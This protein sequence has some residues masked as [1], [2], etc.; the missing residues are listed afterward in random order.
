MRDGGR[1]R[2]WSGRK[3]VGETVNG[4]AVDYKEVVEKG[5]GGQMTV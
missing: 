3:L 4:C 2:K 5:A 1:E